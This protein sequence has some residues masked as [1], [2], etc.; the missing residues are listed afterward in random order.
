MPPWPRAPNQSTR[1]KFKIC[2]RMLHKTGLAKANET[3]KIQ[4]YKTK[5][6]HSIINTKHVK[7][8]GYPLNRSRVC[9]CTKEVRVHCGSKPGLVTTK[10]SNRHIHRKPQWLSVMHGPGVT[11]K[12]KRLPKYVYIYKQY[13]YLR[14][15]PYLWS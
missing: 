5:Y 10:H 2:I 14:S 6:K 1:K 3:H 15:D 4:K 11:T 9:G 13:I 12:N 7:T 8:V